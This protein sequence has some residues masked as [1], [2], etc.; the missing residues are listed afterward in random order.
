[1]TLTNPD[2]ICK[3]K[4]VKGQRRPFLDYPREGAFFLNGLRQDAD[5]K[6]EDVIGYR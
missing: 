1:M 4:D 6:Q 5:Y 2:I 3:I